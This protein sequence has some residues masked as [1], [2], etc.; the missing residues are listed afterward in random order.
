VKK[1]DGPSVEKKFTLKAWRKK[2]KG[3]KKKRDSC[4]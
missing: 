1:G 2:K 4:V 3:R